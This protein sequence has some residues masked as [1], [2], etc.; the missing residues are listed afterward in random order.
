[1]SK[2]KT[3]ALAL[4]AGMAGSTMLYLLLQLLLAFLVV[5]GMVAEDRILTMQIAAA[6]FAVIPGCL[7]AMGYSGLGKAVCAFGVSGGMIGI[8]LTL[9]L[10]CYERLQ[11]SGPTW[12]RIAAILGGGLLC[13]LL[14]QGRGKKKRKRAGVKR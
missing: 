14:R 5:R 1:M 3:M 10:L 12:L 4:V 8:I 9:G 6:L 7:Y 13:V 11:W 2:K